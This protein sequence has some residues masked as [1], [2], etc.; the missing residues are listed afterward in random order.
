MDLRQFLDISSKE[1]KEA[2]LKENSD[3]LLR[4]L[5]IAIESGE[6]GSFQ[7]AVLENLDNY[8]PFFTSFITKTFTKL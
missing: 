1:E 4:N 7:E 8:L 2:F 6:D 5:I 3:L